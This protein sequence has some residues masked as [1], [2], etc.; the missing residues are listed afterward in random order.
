MPD[1]W[2][3]LEF[4]KQRTEMKTDEIFEMAQAAGIRVAAVM[5]TTDHRNVYIHELQRFAQLI[6]QAEREA[7]ARMCD[8]VARNA[9]NPTA[10]AC[11]NTIRAAIGGVY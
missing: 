9:D 10:L 1:F 6:A 2:I 8:Q 3:V 5:D 7:C 11:V 4:L